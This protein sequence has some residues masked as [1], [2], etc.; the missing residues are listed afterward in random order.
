MDTLI[1][2]YQIKGNNLTLFQQGSV[3]DSD[4]PSESEH[5]SRPTIYKLV[6]DSNRMTY[7]EVWKKS[8]LGKWE[9]S[10]TKDLSDYFLRKTD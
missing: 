1:G 9:Q 6:I 5:R 3:Y 4:F 10:E 8:P 7:K 2:T